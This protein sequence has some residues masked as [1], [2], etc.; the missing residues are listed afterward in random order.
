MLA[1]INPFWQVSR[2]TLVAVPGGE[3]RLGVQNFYIDYLEARG[4][5]GERVGHGRDLDS[6]SPIRGPDNDLV[7]T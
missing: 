5:I 4:S 1:S 2:F 7:V 3:L 6:S